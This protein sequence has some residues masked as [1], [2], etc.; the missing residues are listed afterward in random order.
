MD[1]S[2]PKE[3]KRKD[4][5][6]DVSQT[7]QAEFHQILRLRNNLMFSDLSSGSSG[8]VVLSAQH[9]W[10]G[11]RFIL[12][13]PLGSQAPWLWTEA[14]WPVKTKTEALITSELFLGTLFSLFLKK[15][16]HSQAR[17]LHYPRSC[18]KNPTSFFHFFLSPSP[19]VKNGSAPAILIS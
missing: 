10:E 11:Y 5:K 15:N 2:I 9:C 14:I 13:A 16:A 17:L 19:L 18:S 6:D 12:M 8:V 7:Q 4:G 1:I 3:R